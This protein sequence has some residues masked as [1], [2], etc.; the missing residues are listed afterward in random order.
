[1]KFTYYVVDVEG[2]SLSDRAEVSAV[3]VR[4]LEETAVRFEADIPWAEATHWSGE[5]RKA[6]ESLLTAAGKTHTD[7]PYQ[8]TGIMQRSDNEVWR[9]FATFAGYAYD[10]SVWSETR[11]LPLVS[12]A[13]C[14]SEIVVRVDDQ[15]R[16]RLEAAVNPVRVVRLDQVRAERRR[17]R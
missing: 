2:M 15:E 7:E 14:G 13:D 8:Q 17:R 16:S 11:V 6:A 4:T 12:L 5:V 9:A 10:A 1:M 3:T